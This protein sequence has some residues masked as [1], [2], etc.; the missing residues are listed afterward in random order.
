MKIAVFG[1]TGRVGSSFIRMALDQGHTIQALVRDQDKAHN[2]ITEATHIIGDV[3]QEEDIR[4]TVNGCDVVFSSL[5]TDKTTTL[6]KSMPLIRKVMEKQGINR[7]VTIGTAGI[8][9]SRYQEGKYRFQSSESKRTKTFAAE[10]HLKAYLELQSSSLDWTIVCPTY[11]PDEEEMGGVRYEV[12][13]LPKEGK[14]ISTKDTA[15]FA[16]EI[17]DPPSFSKKRVGICY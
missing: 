10:E 6:S 4:A 17:L 11:L 12:D 5:G 1:G 8:L 15:R 9:N 3:T 14:K 2:L 7:V 16:F 13:F